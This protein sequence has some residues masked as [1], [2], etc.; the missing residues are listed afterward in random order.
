MTG[1]QLRHG[2][3][4]RAGYGHSCFSLIDFTS[5]SNTSLQFV[6]AAVTAVAVAQCLRRDDS[7]MLMMMLTLKEEL[8][9][10]LQNDFAS[11]RVTSQ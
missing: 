9:G 10:N 1:A 8:I 2:G 6:V 5:A 7:K 4:N 11:H 3:I